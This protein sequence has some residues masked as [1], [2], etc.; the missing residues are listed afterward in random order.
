L[1]AQALG[2]VPE[3]YKY[4]NLELEVYEKFGKTNAAG[5]FDCHK[6]LGEIYFKNLKVFESFS[7]GQ[8]LNLFVK[9][10]QQVST[11]G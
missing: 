10:D 8:R 11:N 2:L 9:K 6:G 7:R 1:S 3:A 4:L 5:Y